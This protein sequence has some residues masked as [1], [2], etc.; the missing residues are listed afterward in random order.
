MNLNHDGCRGI[1]DTS[2]VRTNRRLDMEDD[3]DVSK[4]SKILTAIF[5]KRKLRRQIWIVRAWEKGMEKA[6]D[7][8]SDCECAF[9]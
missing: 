8:G 1:R 6:G 4:H 7:N 5:K 2:R 3:G 9:I